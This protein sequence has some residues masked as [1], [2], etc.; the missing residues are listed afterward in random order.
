MFSKLALD[1]A[2]PMQ[3]FLTAFRPRKRGRLHTATAHSRMVYDGSPYEFSVSVPMSG[4]RKDS[5]CRR[6]K[7]LAAH[8]Y[9]V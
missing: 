8:V 7:R 9:G 1:E 6:L 4:R 5:A 2:R 3:H